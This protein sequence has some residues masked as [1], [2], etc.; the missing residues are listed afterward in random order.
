VDY[1]R[2]TITQTVKVP[3]NTGRSVDEHTQALI[4]RTANVMD[5]M[6]IGMWPA[7]VSEPQQD[8]DDVL[9]QIL[10]DA[11]YPD[12]VEDAD[13]YVRQGLVNVD[14][15]DIPDLLIAWRDAAVRKALDAV[16]AGS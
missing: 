8:S 14:E 16:T 4:D 13:G 10:R 1:E 15:S 2:R 12:A 6:G 3:T 9:M 11:V 7:V 5:S